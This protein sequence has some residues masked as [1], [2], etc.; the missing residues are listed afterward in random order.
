MKTA[1]TLLMGVLPE[2]R[3][4]GV[5]VAMVYRTMQA[6]FAR[7]I[8]SGECS[9]VLADNDPMNRIMASYGADAYKTYRVYEMPVG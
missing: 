3:Q 6:G 1:R 4:L 8:T 2:Y 5:D 7:G 9:W